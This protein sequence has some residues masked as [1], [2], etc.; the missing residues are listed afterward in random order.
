LL[1]QV[2]CVVADNEPS[3][4]RDLRRPSNSPN[5]YEYLFFVWRGLRAVRLVEAALSP[6]SNANSCGIQLFFG[7]RLLIRWQRSKSSGGH[8]L[9][10]L[11]FRWR[12]RCCWDGSPGTG[13][14]T[15]TSAGE[16]YVD[17][18]RRALRVWSERLARSAVDIASRIAR[19]FLEETDHAI[20]VFGRSVPQG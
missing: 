14:T 2:C 7:S 13:T 5:R 20:F 8:V 19:I 4:D 6:R 10:E 3:C 17:A 9:C 15:S 1:T 16:H 18:R 11:S 12:G